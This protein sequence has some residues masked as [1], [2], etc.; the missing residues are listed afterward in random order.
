MLTSILNILAR[1]ESLSLTQLAQEL[2]SS[3]REIDSALEQMEHM[4]YVRRENYGQACSVNCGSSECSSHCQGCGFASSETYSFW[5][6]TDR[7]KSL[8]GT[9]LS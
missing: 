1:K 9:K 6:L 7:G 4:G 2:N 8:A 5:V 3:Q